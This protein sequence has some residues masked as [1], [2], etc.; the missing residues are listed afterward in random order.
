MV[1]SVTGEYVGKELATNAQ[2][3]SKDVGK[4]R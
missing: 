1:R 3:V 4:V 2:E